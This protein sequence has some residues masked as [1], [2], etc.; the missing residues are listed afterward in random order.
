MKNRT[1]ISSWALCTGENIL[2]VVQIS[3]VTIG[4]A[5]ATVGAADSFSQC[6]GY[7]SFTRWQGMP[8][9]QILEF[10]V[11]LLDGRRDNV[12]AC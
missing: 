2:N 12:N 5:S 8:T 3:A 6:G 1:L 4:G 7:G 10:D 9:D 11:I